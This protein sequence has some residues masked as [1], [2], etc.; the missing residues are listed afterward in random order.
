MYPT[1]LHLTTT[2]T[3]SAAPR[4]KQSTHCHPAE[5][6]RFRPDQQRMG[7]VRRSPQSVLTGHHHADVARSASGNSHLNYQ[8]SQPVKAPE[9]RPTLA[10][11]PVTN[12][13]QAATDRHCSRRVDIDKPEIRLRP[14][15]KNNSM[16]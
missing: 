13:I 3:A 7:P 16:T 15:T 11:S 12:T 4:K 8:P 14:V 9:H 6:N 1:G 5:H 2:A 10:Q